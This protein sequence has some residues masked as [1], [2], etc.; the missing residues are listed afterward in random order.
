[1]IEERQFFHLLVRF[2]METFL[3]IATIKEIWEH[4]HPK[5]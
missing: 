4:W 3:V 2:L 5:W 1:M